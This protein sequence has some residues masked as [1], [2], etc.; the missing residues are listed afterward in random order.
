M[1]TFHYYYFFVKISQWI[2]S[3]T[4]PPHGFC[5]VGLCVVLYI[6]TYHKAKTITFTMACMLC[7][8]PLESLTVSSIQTLG[9]WPGCLQPK[10]SGSL[11]QLSPVHITATTVT[12]HLARL[13]RPWTS[14]KCLLP[15]APKLLASVCPWLFILPF[16]VALCYGRAPT[17]I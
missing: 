16:T 9:I 11:A 17:G 14:G 10:Q 5:M 15:I 1:I 2:L 3:K 6:W 13:N 4:S 8:K 12:Y 7:S